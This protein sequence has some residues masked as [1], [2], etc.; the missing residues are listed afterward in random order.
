[1]EGH[2][3]HHVSSYYTHTKVLIDGSSLPH[4]TF[5]EGILN[6]S[7]LIVTNIPNRN[8]ISHSV[9]AHKPQGC[10]D[11]VPAC[12]P[13]ADILFSGHHDRGAGHWR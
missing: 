8:K 11:K 7:M 5:T 2:I 3:V 13:F 10:S 9:N 6:Q 12:P 4:H 1:M